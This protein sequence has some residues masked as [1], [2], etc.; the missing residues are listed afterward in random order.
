MQPLIAWL[1]TTWLSSFVASYWWAWPLAE[2]LHFLGLSLLIG[3]IGILDLRMLGMAKG[4]SVRSMHRLVP[5]GV[6][7]FVLN[8]VSGI[9]FVAADP[10]RF[11]PSGYFQVKLILIVAAGINVLVFYLTL[12]RESLEWGPE[13]D[14]PASA[15]IVAVTSLLLW[16]AVTIIGRFMAFV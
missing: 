15:K 11:L 16:S 12:Y 9:S 7:G 14:V 13:A 4:L 10:G 3:V 6:L 8:L 5:W 2:T 1:E